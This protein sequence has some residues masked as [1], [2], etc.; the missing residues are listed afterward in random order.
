MEV[1]H[2]VRFRCEQHDSNDKKRILLAI[3]NTRLVNARAR[4][5]SRL[6]FRVWTITTANDGPGCWSPRLYDVVVFSADDTPAMLERVCHPAKQ[7]DPRLLLV[8]LAN[9][10]F[11]TACEIPDAIIAES[12]E[13]AIAEKLVAVVNGAVLSAA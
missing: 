7:A 8:M 4:Q 1:R 13:A 10:P 5:L 9:E 12:D 2:S 11:G 3:R 6:G